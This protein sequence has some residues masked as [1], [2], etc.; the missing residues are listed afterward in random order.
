MTCVLEVPLGDV[1]ACCNVPGW[2]ERAAI[3]Y[4]CVHTHVHVLR[5][6]CPATVTCQIAI[7]NPD[8]QRAFV[9]LFCLFQL[10]N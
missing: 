1:M 6:G 10:F 4:E 8:P 9:F 3:V 2:E 5:R 7:C